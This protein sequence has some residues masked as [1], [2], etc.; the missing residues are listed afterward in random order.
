MLVS[1]AGA[2]ESL[3]V[4]RLDEIDFGDRGPSFIKVDVESMELP[5]M[6][7]AV[8]TLQRWRP[9]MY[10]EDSEGDGSQGPTRLMQFL[11]KQG[12]VSIDL[13]SSGFTDATSML[14]LPKERR[15]EMMERLHTMQW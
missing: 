4:M 12:Y 8:R 10:V 6:Q 13:A 11:Y 14:F 15:E 7:G 5:M 2:L 9:S 1:T 3:R